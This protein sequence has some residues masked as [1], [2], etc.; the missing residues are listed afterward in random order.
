MEILVACEESQEVCAAFRKKG[1]I[2]Y[3]CDIIET[4]GKHPEWHIL[5]DVSPL[6]DG[7]CTFRTQNGAR[8]EI[9]GRWDMIIA[10]PPCTYLCVSG[11]R[12][13]NVARYGAKACYRLLYREYAVEFFMEFVNANCNKIAIENPIGCMSTRYRKPDQ[14]IQPYQF[15]HPYT[16][17]T[18][19][20][21]KGLDP[22]KPTNI[23]EKPKEGWVNQC[24]T[25]DGRY[26]GFKNFNG[27]KN[28]SKTFHGIAEAMANQWG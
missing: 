27:A 9:Y 10:F 22:L 23:L 11:N 18:C 21:L 20:W 5:G 1:H 16:K 8:H 4:S 17:Q 26:G 12:W 7:C 24:I 3:S 19:L 25:P 6:I 28:R 13:F 14:I 2:A 15:G